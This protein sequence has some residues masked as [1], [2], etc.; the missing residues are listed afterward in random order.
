[1][2]LATGLG[3]TFLAAFDVQALADELGRTPRVLFIAHRR[4]LLLQAASTFRKVFPDASMGLFVGSAGDLDAGFV[5]A[6]VHKLALVAHRSSLEPD[7]FDYVV[8]DE[9]H[10]AP[11]QSYRR[12]LKQLEPRFLLGLTATPERADQA[13]VAGLFD[14]H[15][16]FR[17]DLGEGI[18]VGFL[19]PFDYAGLP[20]TIE[21]EPIPWRKYT[22]EELAK[23][24]ET[25]ARMERL[26][27]AWQRYPGT[28]TLVFCVSIRHADYVR[29]W[30]AA[31]G[32]RIVAVHTGDRSADRDTALEQLARGELDAIAAVDLFNEGIDVPRIDRVVML[33]PTGSPVV[34]LQQL[35]H[36]LRVADGKERLQVIDFIGNHRVFLDKV[37]T[38]LS[39]APGRRS[40]GSFLSSDSGEI[41][42]RA[43]CRVNVDLEAIEMLRKFLPS[44]ARNQTIRLYRELRDAREVRPTPG[45]LV[46][47]GMNPRSVRA[48]S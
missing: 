26:F 24:A 18:D 33:R 22:V 20:D 21:F 8:V 43:G 2:V 25:E 37:R 41:E 11:A 31:R 45:E 1:V 44:G 4:E 27:T 19:V 29:E 47:M 36:G 16:A 30:L 46:R 28:R 5:F 12:V 9:S 42:L 39:L 48:K 23:L 40:L 3:K 17:A 10:H 32:V 15:V 13:D 38:L 35:G 6:S 7:R 14:D 34:F